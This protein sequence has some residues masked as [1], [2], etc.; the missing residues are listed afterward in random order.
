MPPTVLAILHRN[1]P[2]HIAELTFIDCFGG[3][4]R[5]LGSESPA[6]LVRKPG[7]DFHGPS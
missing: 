3:A 1:R 2:E 6:F 7:V 5:A 4:V